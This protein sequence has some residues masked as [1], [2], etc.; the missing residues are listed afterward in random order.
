MVTFCRDS[1]T[2]VAAEEGLTGLLSAEREDAVKCYGQYEEFSSEEVYAH[3]SI[4]M[5]SSM[6]IYMF[7]DIGSEK[8]MQDAKLCQIKTNSHD[9]IGLYTNH[10]WG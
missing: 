4:Q 3:C 8:S 9:I 5:K 1:A 7:Y 10:D 6:A 2:P